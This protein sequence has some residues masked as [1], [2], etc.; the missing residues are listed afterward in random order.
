MFAAA[1]SLFVKSN[2]RLTSHPAV[3]RKPVPLG[4]GVVP[5]TCPSVGVLA[6]G[7]RVL[8]NATLPGV[9][10][11]RS[12]WTFKILCAVSNWDSFEDCSSYLQNKPVM[13]NAH[14]EHQVL[15]LLLYANTGSCLSQEFLRTETASRTTATGTFT[16]E[17]TSCAN[18]V[19]YPAQ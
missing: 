10:P 15:A 4:A 18:T 14:V 17:H 2:S 1:A 3:G 11:E 9:P 13:W 16:S 8:A 5:P 7:V 12:S 19:H 6:L